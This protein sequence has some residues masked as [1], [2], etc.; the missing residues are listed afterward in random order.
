M[1][2]EEHEPSQSSPVLVEIRRVGRPPTIV[3]LATYLELG[4]EDL[5]GTRASFFGRC[6]CGRSVE[7]VDSLAALASAL[8][9]L[10]STAGTGS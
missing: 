1:I 4:P 3:D 10:T 9:A 8:R 5:S 6:V 2:C 7:L